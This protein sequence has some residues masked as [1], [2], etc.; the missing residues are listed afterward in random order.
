MDKYSLIALLNLYI[1][2]SALSQSA[3]ITSG[4]VP[5]EVSFSAPAASSYYWDFGNG[6]SSAL[7]NPKHTYSDPG[8]YIVILRRD[9]RSPEIGRLIITAFAEPI[10]E[11]IASPQSGCSPL[12]VNFRA[13]V[14]LNPAVKVIQYEWT[15]GDG[16]SSNAQ[17]P[18]HRYANAKEYNVGLKI[19]T[20][21]KGC[22]K[23]ILS[24]KL[25]KVEGV[26]AR[27]TLDRDYSCTFPAT[28]SI[29]GL[30]PDEPGNS[31]RWLINGQSSTLYNIRSFT[32]P[33]KGT[34]VISYSVKNKA[35]CETTFSDTV[36][37]GPPKIAINAEERVCF[38]ELIRFE[39]STPAWEFDWNFGLGAEIRKSNQR[40]PLNRFYAD[41]PVTVS[42][43][44]STDPSCFSDTTF[45]IIV[46][47][48]DTAFTV[49]PDIACKDPITVNISATNKKMAK[50]IY[51]DSIDRGPDIQQTITCPARDSLHTNR[52]DTFFYTLIAITN[53][54]CRDTSKAQYFIHQK[55]DAHFVPN[56][57]RGC[58]PLE[59]IFNDVST[60]H[61]PIRKWTYLFGDGQSESLLTNNPPV[62]HTYSNPGEY[63][64]KL[65]VE[66]EDGC[67]DTSFGVWIYV[68]AP[69]V[70][71]FT[72]DKR[73]ICIND[74]VTIEITNRDPRIDAVHISSDD[75]RFK[76]CWT[77]PR[78]T[79]GFVTEPGQYD[80]TFMIE[81]NGCIGERLERNLITAK[82]ANADI[83]YMITC[84]APN[85]VMFKN[86]GKNGKKVM[87][88]LGD[89]K[90]SVLDSF[91]H[92]YATTGNYKV[93]LIAEDPASGCPGDLDSAVVFVKNIKAD[94]L[95]P[96]TVCDNQI[97]VLDAQASTDVDRSCNEGFVWHLPYHRPRENNKDTIHHV[98]YKRGIQKVTLV[99]KDINGCRDTFEKEILSVGIDP[100]FA[101]S[102][103]RICYPSSV[104][105][106]DNSTSDLPL[107]EWNWSFGSN[108]KTVTHRFESGPPRAFEVVLSVE[109]I[110]GCR[111]TASRFL[112]V[113]K[114]RSFISAVPNGICA[115]GEI[116]F[117]ATQDFSNGSYLTYEWKFGNDGRDTAQ[118]PKRTFDRPDS[119]K[120]IRLVY[121]E[122]K[123]GCK[124]STAIPINIVVRP[125]AKFSNDPSEKQTLCHP[126]Q[127][128]FFNESTGGGFLT[129]QWKLGRVSTSSEK[130]PSETFPKGIHTITLIANSIYGCADSTQKIIQ[131]VGPEA[132]VA[133]FDSL[134]CSGEEFRAE[135]QNLKDVDRFVWDFKDGNTNSTNNPVIHKFNT[136][137]TKMEPVV[138][139]FSKDNECKLEMRIPVSIA[140]ILGNFDTLGIAGYCPNVVYYKYRIDSILSEPLPDALAFRLADGAVDSDFNKDSIHTRQINSDSVAYFKLLKVNFK[141][142]GKKETSL[143]LKNNKFNCEVIVGDT[144]TLNP[145][146]RFFDMPNVFSPN[147]DM[148][149]DYFYPAL[150]QTVPQSKEE[151]YKSY[152]NVLQ[153]KIYNRFGQLIYDNGDPARGWDGRY[154]NEEAPSEI[155][156]YYIQVE[157]LDCE[158]VEKK[159]NVTIVR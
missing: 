30:T 127:I 151:E 139:L 79:H 51:N 108:Q 72:I 77:N 110:H 22:N 50:Y 73:E 153:F 118:N 47:R 130:N 70:P 34:Y 76:H 135:L 7:Q 56:R 89:Q 137:K 4:C 66:N 13:N 144:V 55:P 115:G 53:I 62:R 145:A 11:I 52:K 42:L 90:T 21:A 125:T 6:N 142:L 37:V 43:K 85:E 87:W 129:Y 105:F 25:V 155:Y 143:I 31:Y 88:S 9:S 78:G 75:F 146:D 19:T 8:Q 159:G 61:K 148:I 97:L 81:Y 33:N 132:T 109:D 156:S 84:A 131:L 54:G 150:K 57:T 23:T 141:T 48:P 119:A 134:L 112:Q 83:G 152:L 86:E 124:D 40:S 65:V 80:V 58:A 2:C 133:V 44:A 10:V 92:R 157:V 26:E 154:K 82:G 107:T 74:S 106:S 123:T 15:F 99:V 45:A 69:I 49:S 46:E 17:S 1:W 116:Q 114:P 91:V 94:L 136:S 111:D 28:F 102:T 103:D 38:G 67:I 140:R 98:F 147:G 64:A 20:D 117:F 12:L 3:D 158:I 36:I 5:L 68:G 14:T 39:N 100:S 121:T 63:Y 96:D 104:T 35:G 18:N 32:I 27:F 101:M 93:Y 138:T 122:A 128:D 59:V 120:I 60:S 24:E 149:N 113:Y 29:T 95:L 41:G 16:V 126:K 71:T